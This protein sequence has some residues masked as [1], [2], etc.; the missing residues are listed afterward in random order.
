MVATSCVCHAIWSRNMLKE[1]SLPQE[2]HTKIFVDN[3]LAI[4]LTKNPVFHDMSKHIDTLYHDIRES[5]TRMDVQLEYVKTNDQV[6]YIF[7]KPLQREEFIQIRGLLGVTKSS[8][9]KGC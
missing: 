3:K 2:E 9:R 7:T 5:V 8:S 1:L 4:A 6:A